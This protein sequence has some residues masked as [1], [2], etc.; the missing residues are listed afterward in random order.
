MDYLRGFTILLVVIFHLT[1]L[2]TPFNSVFVN[3]PVPEKYSGLFMAI[4]FLIN[5][6]FLNTIMFFIAGFFAFGA[7][8]RKGGLSFT[9]DKLKR[10]GLPYL[11]GLIILA[12]LTQYIAEHSWGKADNFFDYFLKE[13][14]LPGTITPGHLWFIGML[15]LFFLISLPVFAVLKNRKRE[16]HHKAHKQII[17]LAIFLIVTFLLY[18]GMNFLYKPYAFISFYI[19]D[20][21]PAL[22]P[23]YASYF[24]LG[25]YASFQ[26]WFIDSERK[27]HIFPWAILYLLSL[28]L[29]IGMFVIMP[30]STEANSPLMAVF[31]TVSILSGVML[32]LTVFKRFLN[33][34]LKRLAW[35]SQNSYG[36]YILHYFI[37][38]L[39]VYLMRELQ[40]PVMVKFI[41]QCIFCPGVIWVLSASLKKFTPLRNI[42]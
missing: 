22:L 28:I 38:F 14:F 4:S 33:K 15:L 40:W 34:P 37:L 2:Y 3:N 31:Y 25:I 9:K 11:G 12:P 32:S 36:A 23:L 20:F 26:K 42:L 16:I 19:L 29:S 18:W 6:T 35:V 24:A 21:P 17:I 8:K 1:L 7:Y 27:E 13:F 10:L 39:T 5:G 41:T 30:N